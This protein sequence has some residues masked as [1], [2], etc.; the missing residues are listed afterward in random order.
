MRAATFI[1][2]AGEARPVSADPRDVLERGETPQH[3]IA[4]PVFFQ[5]GAR[6]QLRGEPG[7][8]VLVRLPRRLSA[9]MRAPG[10]RDELRARRAQRRQDSAAQIAAGYPRHDPRYRPPP[11]GP[12]YPTTPRLTAEDIRRWIGSEPPAPNPLMGPVLETIVVEGEPE[13]PEIRAWERRYPRRGLGLSK[14]LPQRRRRAS[15]VERSALFEHISSSLHRLGLDTGQALN[16]AA[17]ARL[18]GARGAV[19]EAAERAAPGTRVTSYEVSDDGMVSVQLLAPLKA[20]QLRMV[21]SSDVVKVTG[22]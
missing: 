4:G 20:I 7:D 13:D 9:T 18:L 14:P 17:R 19:E 22:G 2:P 11:Q 1:A 16:T 15:P 6:P 8:P 21:V 3:R 12:A 5:D 10:W